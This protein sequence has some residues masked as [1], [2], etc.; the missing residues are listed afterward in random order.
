MTPHSR[1]STLI[2]T[3]TAERYPQSGAISADAPEAGSPV[4]GGRPGLVLAQS[5]TTVTWP[6][7]LYRLKAV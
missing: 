5:L 3:L 2:G 6:S 1:L 7:G 4:A